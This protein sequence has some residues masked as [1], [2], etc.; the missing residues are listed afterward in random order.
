ML[1]IKNL[2][3]LTLLVY[4]I[5]FANLM[6]NPFKQTY[7]LPILNV[8]VTTDKKV[9][10]VGETIQV[11][12]NL[13]I[14]GQPASNGL[15]AV[16][17][18]DPKNALYIIRTCLIGST[19]PWK[20]EILQVYLSDQVGNPK[21]RV[22]RG[23]LGYITIIWRNNDNVSHQ[24]SIT[25]NLYYE[26]TTPFLASVPF[27][28]NVPAGKQQNMTVSVPIP[29]DAPTGTATVY[30]SALSTL[31]INSGYAYCPEK[32]SNFTITKSTS[33]LS[34]DQTVGPATTNEG[35]NIKF[36]TPN[37]DAKLG[38][39]TIYVTA[40]C[41]EQ[42]AQAIY[43]F[44]L[45]LLGDVNFDGKVDMSDIGLILRA[46]GTKKG[47]PKWNPI[48]DLNSDEKVDM[49]DIGIILRNFGNTGKY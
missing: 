11:S 7:G 42:T 16:Q 40:I 38:N 32:H 46:Y 31:P 14:D 9:Y 35:Y 18:N 43:T 48:Y 27:A 15:V 2:R 1:K 28:G 29:S 41:Q 36:K 25:I 44:K 3:L 6:I 4:L 33:S 30:A 8:T 24:V 37:R 49:S 5:I 45:V 20:I 34:Q 19:T 47:D 13:T 21:D 26:D 10:N 17:I 12:G 39:Y 22:S 23:T